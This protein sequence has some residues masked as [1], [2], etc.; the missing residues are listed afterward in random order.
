MAVSAKVA[1]HTTSL[2]RDMTAK[3]A[4]S[5][6]ENRKATTSGTKIP[7]DWS[8]ALVTAVFKKDNISDPSN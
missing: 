1:L 3:P 8:K 7:S 4:T 6:G 2:F 5:T